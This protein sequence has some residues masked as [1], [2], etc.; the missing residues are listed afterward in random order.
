MVLLLLLAAYGLAFCLQNKIP[1]LWHKHPL[2][3]RLLNC[4]YCTGFHSGWI[5]IGAA[6]TSHHL[7]GSFV[8]GGLTW[9]DMGLFSF[10]SSAFVYLLDAAARCLESHSDPIEV[11]VEEDS[12]EEE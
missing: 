4:T 8:V 12:E 5:V 1:F 3:D 2:L 6:L 7:T 11:E 10:A 9:L